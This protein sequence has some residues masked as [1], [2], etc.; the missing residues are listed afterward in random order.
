MTKLTPNDLTDIANESGISH[1]EFCLEQ[2]LGQ[3]DYSTAE[4]KALKMRL[5]ALRCESE[6]E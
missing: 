2:S 4:I 6:A 3:I 5:E 1:A